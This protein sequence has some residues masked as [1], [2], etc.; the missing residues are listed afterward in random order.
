MVEEFASLPDVGDKL[1]PL[2]APKETV[3]PYVVYGAS[4]GL[5]VSTLTGYGSS[6]SLTVD[7]NVVASNYGEMK[8]HSDAALALLISFQGREI[9]E[10]GLFIQQLI[11]EEPDEIYEDE[12]RLHKC[13]IS[14]TVHI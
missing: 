3:A 8:Q 14:F 6:K 11:L 12:T 13:V 1:F 9:G 4:P 7:M 10:E 5:P 2:A